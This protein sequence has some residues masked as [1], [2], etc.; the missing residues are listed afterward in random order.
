MRPLDDLIEARDD[1]I[2][3]VDHGRG[4]VDALEHDHVVH[5]RLGQHV[6]L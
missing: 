5:A 6:A 2:R 1:L 3:L 4:V